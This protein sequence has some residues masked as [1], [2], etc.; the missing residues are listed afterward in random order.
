MLSFAR[1]CKGRIDERKRKEKCGED[2][3]RSYSQVG[4][5]Y[6]V[7]IGKVASTVIEEVSSRRSN[8]VAFASLVV[9][10]RRSRCFSQ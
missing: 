1:R 3:A 7:A 4:V 5:K 2:G 10:V 9:V 8:R 6:E